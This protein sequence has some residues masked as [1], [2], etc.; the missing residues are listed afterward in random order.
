MTTK[1]KY[2][3]GIGGALLVAIVAYVFYRRR[4]KTFVNIGNSQWLPTRFQDSRMGLEMET[5]DHGFNVGDLIEIDHSQP[6][7]P[8]GKTKVIDVVTK[9]GLPFIITELKVSSETPDFQGKVRV[10]S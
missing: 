6:H 7:L 9:N 10:V 3:I 4:W 8:K 5:A 2:S 1:Q